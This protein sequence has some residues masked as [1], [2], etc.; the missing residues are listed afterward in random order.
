M[1]VLKSTKIVVLL[2]VFG[3]PREVHF[4]ILLRWEELILK[5]SDQGFS[6][7]HFMELKDSK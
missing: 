7:V 3:S 1:D 4:L 5:F 2:L 6:L